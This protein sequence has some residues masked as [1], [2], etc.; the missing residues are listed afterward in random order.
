MT[1]D[2]EYVT[3]FFKQNHHRI[4]DEDAALLEAVLGEYRRASA[5]YTQRCQQ[6]TADHREA[7]ECKKSQ[8][9]KYARLRAEIAEQ[10]TIPVVYRLLDGDSVE[11]VVKRPLP[12]GQP[13]IPIRH[14]MVL[15]A[16]KLLQCTGIKKRDSRHKIITELLYR[17]DGLRL[18]A[19]TISN[20]VSRGCIL[21]ARR[22]IAES[23]LERKDGANRHNKARG[24]TRRNKNP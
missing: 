18:E 16:D 7:E 8:P 11:F 2:R 1:I 20:D 22:Q 19:R 23:P 14:L 6:L 10:A 24:V 9:Q 12:G 17:V 15:Q 3:G 21:L 13:G 4:S 5:E